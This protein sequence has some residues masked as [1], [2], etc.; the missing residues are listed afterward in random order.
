MENQ[1]WDII[2]SMDVRRSSA[3]AAFLNGYIYVTGGLN[4]FYLMEKSV[5]LYTPDSDSWS[6]AFPSHYGRMDFVLAESDGYLYAM[7]NHKAIERFEPCG[8]Y[9]T[10]V[11]DKPALTPF[12]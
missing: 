4:H 11:S 12:Q 5:E 8:N 9:W 6:Q 1:T 10:E 2:K 3:A 7:G